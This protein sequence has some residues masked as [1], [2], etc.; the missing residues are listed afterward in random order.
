[1]TD[2]SSSSTGPLLQLLASGLQIWIR[3]QCDA[4]GELKLEL[5]GSALG[6]LRGRLAGVSLIAKE[7]IF[8]GLPLHHAEL[9][10]GPLKL[11]INLGKTGQSVNLQQS[12]NIE[13]NIS[14]KDKDLNKVLLSAPWDWLGDWLAEELI[15][16]T[17]LGRLKIDN[18]I[19]ELQAPAIGQQQ[20]TR[21][22]FSVRA[23]AG[24]VLIRHLDAEAE[25]SLPMDPAIH[26]EEASLKAGQLHL[27]GRASVTP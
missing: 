24:T 27:K 25:A 26:I 7:V 3:R 11:N 22:H 9:K 15:G 16:I 5:H 1:M 8:Q 13:G 14:I 2:N 12:F 4:V 20:P 17:P 23:D 19:L 6:L 18:E 21:R 10:S